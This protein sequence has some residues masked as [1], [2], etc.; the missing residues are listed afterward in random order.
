M[1][2]N[3]KLIKRA[4]NEINKKISI[5]DIYQITLVNET[6]QTYTIKQLNFNKLKTIYTMHA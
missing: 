1:S 5:F 6:L 4:I 2:E 3:I